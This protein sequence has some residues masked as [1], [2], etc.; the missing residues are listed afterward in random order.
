MLPASAVF[1]AA[2]AIALFVSVE[3]GYFRPGD[4]PAG[5]ASAVRPA[6]LA[7][8]VPVI[9]EAITVH[10]KNLPVEV[11]GTADQVH[12]WFDGKLDITARPPTLS[13]DSVELRGARVGRLHDRDAAQYVYEVQSPGSRHTMTVSVFDAAGLSMDGRA[14]RHRIGGHEVWSGS[15]RGFSVVYY[16]R[17]G[18]GYA[19][20]SDMGEDELVRLVAR[21]I[22]DD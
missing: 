3:T 12:A 19:Y 13:G 11:T 21:D 5:P 8:P 18:V 4:S 10:Q 1:A 20:T 7:L 15:A 17:N 16:L 22:A 6:N 14:T 2:A 9:G